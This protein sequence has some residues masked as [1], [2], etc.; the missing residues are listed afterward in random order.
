[1]LDLNHIKTVGDFLEKCSWEFE[2]F[3]QMNDSVCYLFLHGS[4]LQFLNHVEKVDEK[5]IVWQVKSEFWK[6][7]FFTTTWDNLGKVYLNYNKKVF[8]TSCQ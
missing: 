6:R 4:E 5:F 8:K 3:F 2:L 1:M 7:G